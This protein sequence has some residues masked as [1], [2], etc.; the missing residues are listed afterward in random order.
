MGARPWSQQIT[1]RL[2][3]IF[4]SDHGKAPDL[5]PG[6]VELGE[7]LGVVRVLFQPAHERGH[8]TFTHA[9]ITQTEP[10]SGGGFD[11]VGVGV[12][13]RKVKGC[14]HGAW[15]RSIPRARR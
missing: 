11:L 13:G 10:N 4:R 6:R 14:A 1:I 3:V 7:D 9:A 8:F 2:D 12:V 5:L 15:L